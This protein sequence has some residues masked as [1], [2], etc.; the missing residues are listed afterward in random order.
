MKDGNIV[1]KRKRLYLVLCIALAVVIPSFCFSQGEWNKWYFGGNAALDFS[2]GIPV[3]LNDNALF[4]PR[5][6]T[7]I[8]DSTGLLLFYSDGRKVYNRNHIIMPNGNGLYVG[9]NSFQPVSAVQSPSNKNQYYIF[10]VG[11]GD[12]FNPTHGLYFSILDMT[13]DGGFG[14]ILPGSKNIAIANADSAYQHIATTRHNNNKDIWVVV[15]NR[16]GGLY[17]YEAFLITEVGINTIPVTSAGL[18]FIKPLMLAGQMRISYDGRKIFC[19]RDT[20]GEIGDFNSSTGEITPLFILSPQQGIGLPRRPLGA[21]FSKNSNYLYISTVSEANPLPLDSSICAGYQYDASLSD[22]TLFMQSEYLVGYGYYNAMQLGPDN[23]IYC[24]PTDSNGF[25]RRYLDCIQ[26]PTQQGSACG[27]KYNAVGLNGK[28]AMGSLPQYLQKY[29]VYINHSGFCAEDSISFSATVWPAID[30]CIWN[31]GDPASGNANNS[32]LLHPRHSFNTPGVYTIQL[33]VKHIDN[34]FDTGYLTLHISD[35]PVPSLGTDRSM[36]I[37]DSTTLDAGFCTG[38]TYQWDNFAAGQINIGNGQTLTVYD[39]GLYVVHVTNTSGCTGRD[40][41]QVS[42]SPPP[43]L[44]TSPLDKSICS[45][46]STFIPLSSNVPAA[47]FSWTASLTSGNISGF[48]ADSGM[49][50]NQILTNNISSPGIVTYHI[51]PKVGNCIGDTTDYAVTVDPRDTASVSITASANMICAGTSVTFTATPVNG[52]TT[53]TYQWQVN[54]VNAGMN[55]PV[56]TY[57]PFTNDHIQCILTSSETVCISNNPDTS[58]VITMIVNPNLSVSVSVSP[59]ANPFCIGTPVTFTAS[60]INGG[61]TPNY[62]WQVNGVNVGTNS[63]VFTYL[64]MTNDKVQIILTSSEICTTNNPDTTAQITMIGFPGL[65]ADVTIT[66][67]PSPSCQGVLVTFTA[68]PVN[69]GS[70]PTYQWQVNGMNVGTNSPFYTYIPASL[71]LVSCIMTSNLVCVTNNPASSIQYPVSISPTPAVTFTPCF[72]TITTTNAKPIKLKGGI[73]LGGNYTGPGVV[74]GYFY[75]NLAGV[76]TH[77]ITYTYV[78]AALCSNSTSSRIH[79]FTNP[80]FNCGN[81]W[82]D[83]RDGKTYPTIQIGGQCWF[84]ANLDYGIQIPETAHQRDN[85]ISEKYKSAVGSPQSAVY[86]WDEMMLYD[87]TPGLQGLCPPN[88]HIPS[89]TEWGVLFANWTN[90]AFA[91]APLKYSGY[92]GFNALLTGIIPQNTISQF[93]NF[94]IFFWS[95]TA[96]GPYKAW[97]HGMNDP[98]FSVSYYPSLRSNAFSVRCL[99]D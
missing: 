48:S 52:G 86:Q 45:G 11:D 44:T 31:F 7:S 20:I 98:D 69:G 53:P 97:A 63:T 6:T 59:S 71:D 28:K 25:P 8:S 60:P 38:C 95:S 35:K 26:N 58:N 16:T 30:S 10:T 99:R 13:L 37:G 41:V 40:T 61:T 12:L 68:T 79:E 94:A 2:S 33:I 21:E 80:I 96:Y 88:W 43:L 64:P 3:S 91:A 23:K 81:N 89:E 82:I 51:T 39:S 18:S 77:V 17:K 84:A 74:A 92:S 1:G 42:V 55:S 93:H 83:I 70:N 75:P 46:D 76:G 50:I 85:C 65:P 47:T 73:P 90:N 54:G 67:S 34:R 24:C 15:I 27:I 66:A 5:I 87:N 72:D 56:F 14:D 36:C 29:Y 32:A 62:Q 22:S 19:P 49:I 9:L 57:L 4:T 78:N